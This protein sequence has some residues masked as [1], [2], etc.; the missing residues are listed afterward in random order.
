MCTCICTWNE[1]QNTM[2]STFLYKLVIITHTDI[3]SVYWY[4]A[5]AS[6]DQMHMLLTLI[7][8]YMY[9]KLSILS[10]DFIPDEKSFEF[11]FFFKI[12]AVW[13]MKYIA[14]KINFCKSR[15]NFASP[16]SSN[17]RTGTFQHHCI[18]ATDNCDSKKGHV[19]DYLNN[20]YGTANPMQINH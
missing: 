14:E 8:C 5:Q 12:L 10:L 15:W 17:R 1:I 18:W 3:H 20:H 6:V 9:N 11:W 16:I 4:T 13:T 19:W 2:S 7:K